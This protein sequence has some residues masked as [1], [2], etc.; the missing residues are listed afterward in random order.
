MAIFRSLG[1]ISQ[2]LADFPW[3]ADFFSPT[4]LTAFLNDIHVQ[5]FEI[6]REGRGF[7]STLW[8]ALRKELSLSLPGF[9]DARLVAGSDA[10]GLTFVTARLV[11]GAQSSLTFQNVKLA[12]RFA[13]DVLRPAK[14]KP[15]DSERGFAEIQ[16]EGSISIDGSYNLRVHGFNALKLTPV[17]IAQTGII[18]SA[19]EVKLDL[20]RTSGL[21][22][23]TAAGFDESFMGVFIGKAAVQLPA[24]WP[25]L[26]PEHLFLDRC[27]IGTGG[28]SGELHATY[29]P[30]FDGKLF[31]GKGAG[32][33]FGISFGIKEVSLKLKQNSF[34]ESRISGQLLLPYF[35]R[36]LQVE[37]AVDARGG[38][39]VRATG[40]V[41]A[42]DKAEGK[43]GVLTLEKPGILRLEVDSIAFELEDGLFTTKL[44]G[45]LT[46]LFRKDE[47]TWPSV[48]VKEL[49]IDSEGN[50]RLD[51]GWLD[52]PKKYSLDFYGFAIELTKLGFGKS[53]G[54]KWIGFSGGVK[55]VDGFSAGASV[56]GL[57][58]TWYDDGREPEISLKGLGVELVVPEVLTLKGAVAYEKSTEDGKAVHRFAGGVT[59]DIERLK[60]H[61]DGALV[62]GTTGGSPFGALYLSAELPKGIP[63]FGTNVALYGLAGLFAVQMEPNR[64]PEEE[65]YRGW[66]KR[67]PEGTDIKKKW[68][69][70]SGSFALGA[71]ATL[72]TLN[73]NGYTFSGRFLLVFIFPGPIVLL[74]GQANI[75]KERAKLAGEP[76]FRALAVWD[77]RAGTFVVG[78]DAAFKYPPPGGAMVD[79]KGGAEALYHLHDGK[80][81]YIH[82]GEKEPRERRL[83]ARLYKLFD[84]DAYLMI[85]P[86]EIAL[87]AWVGWNKRWGFSRLK[88]ALEAWIEANAAL[89]DKPAQFHGDL[90]LHGKAEL[91]ISRFR[92]GM[93]VDAKITA[94][95]D[96]PRHVV[97]HFKVGIKLPWPLSSPKVDVRL[98]WGPQTDPPPLPHP[99]KE[100]AV[101]H[102]K[103]TTSWPLAA[104]SLLLPAYDG[105]GDGF[106]DSFT[107]PPVI[108]PSVTDPPVPHP[109]EPLPPPGGLPIVPLDARPLLTFGRS[110]HDDALLGV[111]PQPVQPNAEPPGWEWIGDPA[112]QKGVARAR[113]GLQEVALHSWN[114]TKWT[115]VARKRARLKSVSPEPEYEM[116]ANLDGV[117]ELYGSWAPLPQI[118]GGKPV[119]GSDPPVAQTKLWLWS[120]TPFDF[121]AEAGGEWDDWFLTSHPRYPCVDVAPGQE[122]C[123]D[124]E[125]VDP[126]TRLQPPWTHPRDPRVT[127]DWTAA[128][129]QKVTLLPQPVGKQTRALCFPGSVSGTTH[130]AP[131]QVEIRLA[132][133]ARTVRIH[134]A[135]EPFARDCLSFRDRPAKTGPNPYRERGFRL[136]LREV[137]GKPARSSR[138]V[139][140]TTAEGP[141]SGLAVAHELEIA[142]L[143]PSGTVDLE[144][145]PFAP[146]GATVGGAATLRLEA[147]D[148]DGARTA[149][150]VL[151][152][153]TGVPQTASLAGSAIARLILRVE[154]GR[155]L[156]HEICRGPSS[157]PSATGFG[158]DGRVYGPFTAQGRTIEV[159]GTSL[160]RVAVHGRERTCIVEV[161]ATFGLPPAEAERRRAMAR[162]LAAETERWSGEGAVLKPDTKYRLRIV[163]TVEV[164]EH[165]PRREFKEAF[166]GRRTLTQFAYFRTGGPPGV[167]P[168]VGSGLDDLGL[169][170]CQT[171]PATVPG[172]GEKPLLPRPV[173]RSYDVGV[174]FNESYV[175]LLYR[176][177]GREL[178]L[179]LVDASGRP[180]RDAAGRPLVLDNRWGRASE[181]TLTA[182]EARWIDTVNAR[183]C[184]TI[185]PAVIVHSRIL[186]VVDENLVLDPDALYEARLVARRA[187]GAGPGPVVYRFAFTTSRFTDFLHHL[188]SFDDETWR[189]DLAPPPA[190][191][192]ALAAAAPPDAPPADAEAERRAYEALAAALGTAARR[193]PARVEAT[194]LHG[195]GAA[196]ALLVRSPEPIDWR[197]TTLEVLFA[198]GRAPRAG[199]PGALKLTAVGFAAAAAHVELLAR[200]TADLTGVGVEVRAPGESW[201][202]Y[203]TFAKEPL[204]P[205]GRRLRIYAA[206][207]AAPAPAPGVLHRF[208]PATAAAIPAAGA[209]L[210]LVSPGGAAGHARPFLPDTA[211]GPAGGIRVLRNGDGTGVFLVLPSPSPPGSSLRPGEYRLRWT[212][213]RDNRA[214][215]P[216]SCVLSKAG[217]STPES[218]VLD[219]P[220]P[221][222]RT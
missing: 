200:E 98:E 173:Y 142:L 133:P 105:D 5:D 217:D 207:A 172:P 129:T 69:F 72:G 219:L 35:D 30:A 62:F 77:N 187:A 36:R 107:D 215:E 211:Y 158:P 130:G 49:A 201:E 127:F 144:L 115:D 92:A 169:Y 37:I 208:A 57:R 123:W 196:W 31:T 213:R 8:L 43:T 150:A 53:G 24:G 76:D 178:K 122:V 216:G 111:N 54:G 61:V 165:P 97:G 188:H 71:G 152:G 181:R 68:G 64:K 162:R 20:S 206:G 153:T 203:F 151:P 6:T 87:G 186:T 110:V 89:S 157:P 175:D 16:V 39:S 67:A 139:V 155:A 84:A 47:I 210:R 4:D 164:K 70:H 161:C 125:A 202:P 109:R 79:L 58:I 168:A 148:E 189:L 119:P 198:A 149:S 114:G 50:V 138:I 26:A 66:Y 191:A 179:E 23:V 41:E 1:P 85:A 221:A 52:L 27:A 11:V 193:A 118:P 222:I 104:G 192:A 96:D 184:A 28:V 137:G 214:A 80:N 176:L 51:G 156:L 209:E 194:R 25:A 19:E 112:Q 103:V 131:P 124:F 10:A 143:R 12:L 177:A 146:G 120:L 167:P 163:T 86:G 145:T 121:T 102:F 7:S 95:V 108:D 29:T 82:L 93:T 56:E 38:L 3:P 60:L 88:V 14:L 141:R 174:E 170:V 136:A 117:P 45:K 106:L 21:P 48:E 75:L 185:D 46:P 154:G 40:A 195:A 81:W 63:L 99:V 34:Q 91:R 73:D 65:W 9:R 220:W 90:W 32:K 128:G 166:A 182:S 190:L 180:A 212:Y 59:V 126:A 100:V 55:L 135:Q 101:G 74:Q 83:R 160:S 159:T 183:G 113:Y 17:A 15:E 33:L 22:E 140:E 94:E 44:S 205:A 134:L 197:R 204:L 199:R 147:F 218:A 18:I 2:S 116:E 171:V 42:G 132:E 78:L 13:S